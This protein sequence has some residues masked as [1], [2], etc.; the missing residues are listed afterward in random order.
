MLKCVVTQI[1]RK[2]YLLLY[3]LFACVEC[4]LVPKSSCTTH[5]PFS[6]QKFLSESLNHMEKMYP[7]NGSGV[8]SSQQSN[9]DTNKSKDSALMND[10]KKWR[11]EDPPTSNVVTSIRHSWPYNWASVSPARSHDARHSSK[12]GKLEKWTTED[13]Y[14][15]VRA[16]RA[17]AVSMR[18]GWS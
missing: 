17:A 12:R 14:A 16:R 13:A 1:S 18:L 4:I 5:L 6:L 8:T 15:R 3:I 10:M 2:R 9:L 11:P 7:G